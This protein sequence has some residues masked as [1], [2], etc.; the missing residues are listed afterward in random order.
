[1]PFNYGIKSYFISK[2]T[3]IANVSRLNLF[4]TCSL[5]SQ[6]VGSLGYLFPKLKSPM[7][8]QNQ[9]AQVNFIPVSFIRHYPFDFYLR[10]LSP[11]FLDR[12]Y[13]PSFLFVLRPIRHLI[14]SVL[15]ELL[16][17]ASSLQPNPKESPSER[18]YQG[19][20]CGKMPLRTSLCPRLQA[21]EI[22]IE[23]Y[24]QITTPKP[25]LGIVSTSPNV[26]S[27]LWL[28]PQRTKIF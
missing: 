2:L 6:S 28:R 1:M 22:G 13:P 14:S 27:Y 20:P 21:G 25:R 8:G 19:L 23:G 18:L 4:N 26:W 5:S 7:P 11:P 17:L 3:P 16:I 15:R 10:F 12:S 24:L 9:A